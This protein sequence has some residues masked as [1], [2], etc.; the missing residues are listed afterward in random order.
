M[1]VNTNRC[2]QKRAANQQAKLGHREVINP[3]DEIGTEFPEEYPQDD[4]F[5]YGQ[6]DL[7]ADR[8]VPVLIT[9]PEQVKSN[10]KDQTSCPHIPLDERLE[11]PLVNG[12]STYVEP[13]NIA[14]LAKYFPEGTSLTLNN[15]VKF[16]EIPQLMSDEAMMPQGGVGRVERLPNIEKVWER[17][18]TGAG[19]KIVVID[20]GIH[21]HADLKEKVVEWVDFSRQKH[22]SMMDDYGHGTHVAGVA[23]GDGTQSKGE[24]VG[25]A[26]DAEVVGL[27]ITT[28]AEAIKALQWCVEN[29]ERLDLDV[30]N[31]SLGEVARRGHKHDPWAVAVQ[32]ASEAGLTVVVAAGNEGPNEGTISTP[33]IHPNAIT[34]GAYDSK[35]TPET[36]DDTVWRKSSQGLTIDGLKK[37]DVLAPG[38]AIFAPLAP[39]SHLDNQSFPHRG[40]DYL[41]ISG[42]SQAT[43]MIAGLVA[44]LKQAN[45]NLTSEQVKDVLRQASSEAPIH[46]TLGRP[47]DDGAGLVN[48]EKA[49]DLALAMGG[50][51]TAVA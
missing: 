24:I 1:I 4:Y 16:P 23:A 46:P 48:A 42:T 36:T 5:E 10:C 14:A 43:P 32:K 13:Q 8:R 39:K 18:F 9:F 21:P 19:Q 40:D 3:H 30:I 27:R 25:I 7:T 37:P 38:V 26:P 35:G 41:A 12:F 49:L 17:G 22:K 29:K 33:G 6:S 31:M 11:L 45:P 50:N 2:A 28:K 34:V 47:S 15:K 44:I 20:S 51:H